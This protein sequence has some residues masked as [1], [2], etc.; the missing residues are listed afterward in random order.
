MSSGEWPMTAGVVPHWAGR[1][2]KR[3]YKKWSPEER[4]RLARLWGEGAPLEQLCDDFGCDERQIYSK[5]SQMGLPRRSPRGKAGLGRKRRKNAA[6]PKKHGG[7]QR[8][9]MALLTVPGRRSSW[10]SMIHDRAPG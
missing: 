8:R 2:V 9:F 5:A 10:P 3:K 7:S 1:P 6:K 4:I